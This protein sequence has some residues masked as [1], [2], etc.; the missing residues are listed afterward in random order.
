MNYWSLINSMFIGGFISYLGYG[1]DTFELW[2][3]VIVINVF[4]TL[5]IGKAKKDICKSIED[6]LDEQN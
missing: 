2:I 6:I 1:I 4:Q 5:A 3:G